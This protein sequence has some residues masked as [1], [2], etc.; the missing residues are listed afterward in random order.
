LKSLASPHTHVRQTRTSSHT[1]DRPFPRL[2]HRHL[3]YSFFIGVQNHIL[4][5]SSTF[6]ISSTTI[7]RVRL[8]IHLTRNEG[9]RFHIYLEHA[10]LSKHAHHRLP[11]SSRSPC[12]MLQHPRNLPVT[13]LKPTCHA[14]KRLAHGELLYQG[15]RRGGM[16]R[17]FHGRRAMRGSMQGRAC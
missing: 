17:S 7:R 5:T 6:S 2:T 3:H 12:F 8:G 14:P 15:H 13:V 9:L 1:T 11:R 16:L 10:P 4:L